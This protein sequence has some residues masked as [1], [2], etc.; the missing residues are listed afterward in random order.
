MA[1]ISKGA[2]DQME[3]LLSGFQNCPFYVEEGRD[4]VLLQ[5]AGNN[6][7]GG[8]WKERGER[9]RSTRES[10]QLTAGLLSAP[11]RPLSEN[12]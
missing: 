11:S 6:G 7:G 9:R 12:P 4:L 5:R 1:V 10:G 2:P 3:W 8:D